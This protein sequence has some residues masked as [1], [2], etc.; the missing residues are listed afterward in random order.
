MTGRGHRPEFLVRSVQ[1]AG[2]R[3]IQSAIESAQMSAQLTSTVVYML[4]LAEN[5]LAN[6]RQAGGR[7]LGLPIA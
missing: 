3:L 5:I 1:L 2:A 7:L 4:Q 6:P